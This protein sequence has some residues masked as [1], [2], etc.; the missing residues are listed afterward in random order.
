MF[1]GRERTIRE[2]GRLVREHR[3][4][5]R[6][7]WR[8]IRDGLSGLSRLERLPG[9]CWLNRLPRLNR[10]GR[11]GSRDHRIDRCRIWH[12]WIGYC[13]HGLRRHGLCRNRLCRDWLCRLCRLHRRPSR[14]KSLSRSI[15]NDDH[16]HDRQRQQR[17]HIF[18][19]HNFFSVW[20]FVFGR[21]QRVLAFGISVHITGRADPLPWGVTL[22]WIMG[23]HRPPKTDP[24]GSCISSHDPNSFFHWPCQV[25]GRGTL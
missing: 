8:L 17:P 18:T 9:L 12:H 15:Q 1:G 3:R 4:T 25:R 22:P 5:I 20:L 24:A 19:F 21:H 14:F 2:H 10:R 6:E 11:C 7:Y 23:G 16:A 13:R